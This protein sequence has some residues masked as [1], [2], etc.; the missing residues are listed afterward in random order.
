MDWPFYFHP[1]APAAEI[2]VVCFLKGMLMKSLFPGRTELLV[3]I[4]LALVAGAIVSLGGSRDT[5]LFIVTG[6][7]FLIAAL[8]GFRRSLAVQPVQQREEIVPMSREE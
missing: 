7:V 2:L 1:P 8:L 4:A 6:P 5:M 3:V